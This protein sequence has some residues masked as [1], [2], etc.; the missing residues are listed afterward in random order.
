MDRSARGT[1]RP[2][3][4]RDRAQPAAVLAAGH[5]IEIDVDTDRRLRAAAI[6]RHE[7]GARW[8]IWSPLDA[9]GVRPAGG[10]WLDRL[11]ATRVPITMLFAEG[12][13]GIVF[14]RTRL[15]RRITRVQRS[16]TIRVTEVPGIDHPM[17]RVWLR[18]RMLQALHQALI[19]I[20]SY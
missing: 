10:R 1:A 16:G 5:P 15:A 18:P 4:R 7:L 19:E 14:L 9:L 17:H 12:D 2:R 6:H 11:A 8:H 13:D 3:R 20:E